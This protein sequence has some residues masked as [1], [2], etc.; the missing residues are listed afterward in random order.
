MFNKKQGFTLIELLVV[1]AI[2]AIL[3]SIALLSLA[4]A[5]KAGRDARRIADLRNTQSVLQLDYNK[6]GHFPMGIVPYNFQCG[7]TGGPAPAATGSSYSWST[8][9]NVL[10]SDHDAVINQP[11]PNDPLGPVSTAPQFFAKCTATGGHCYLYA[12]SQDGLS[13][14]LGALL[15]SD[16]AA[17]KTSFNAPDPADSYSL[18][19]DPTQKN[20]CVKF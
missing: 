4:P 14:I 1:I 5:Q 10:G 11:L 15:E 13:Y 9:S 3:A 6:C 20:Y 2:I 19:C 17:L 8:L 16:N 12:V 18:G 7:A